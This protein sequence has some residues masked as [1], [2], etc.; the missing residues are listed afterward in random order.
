M[1]KIN[2]LLLEKILNLQVILILEAKIHL[3]NHF[4]VKKKKVVKVAKN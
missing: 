4:L 1:I 3:D 2:Y